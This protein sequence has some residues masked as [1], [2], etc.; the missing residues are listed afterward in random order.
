M[1]LLMPNPRRNAN[2]AKLVA[3]IT[4]FIGASVLLDGAIIAGIAFLA[5]GV[6]LF[7]L[8]GDRLHQ[9]SFRGIAAFVG[10]WLLVIIALGSPAISG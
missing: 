1:G 3:V 7:G 6:L 8:A 4:G 5:A 9:I 10:Y 2:A